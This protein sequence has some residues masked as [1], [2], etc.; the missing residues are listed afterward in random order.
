MKN[1]GRKYTLKGSPLKGS[2]HAVWRVVQSSTEN[3]FAAKF[4]TSKADFDRE[5]ETL[6][7]LG[8]SR[9]TVTLSSVLEENTQEEWGKFNI[10]MLDYCEITLKEYWDATRARKDVSHIRVILTEIISG[11]EH[12]HKNGII[13]CDIKPENIMRYRPDSTDDC[14]VLVDFDSARE[15]GQSADI[16]TLAYTAPELAKAKLNNE[17]VPASYSLD[18]WGLGRVLYYLATMFPFWPDTYGE[19][20]IL[21]CLAAGKYNIPSD[22]IDARTHPEL[23]ELLE[24]EPSKRKT[25]SSFKNSSYITNAHSTKDLKE[26]VA[27]ARGDMVETV[28]R[29]VSMKID[30]STDKILNQI[31]SVRRQMLSIESHLMPRIFMLSPYQKEHTFIQ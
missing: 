11:L 18:V 14:W 23:L 22:S 5:K 19:K 13:H 8:K 26:K 25:L 15:V 9:N 28:I 2:R 31:E 27:E 17:K 3:I 1:K 29:Q 21:E 16:C 6:K 30:E 20:E 24:V 7:K 4:Y 10:L 12:C